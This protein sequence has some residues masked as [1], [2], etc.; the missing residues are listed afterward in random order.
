MNHGPCA[1][2]GRSGGPSG[3]GRCGAAAMASARS[4]LQ[5]EALDGSALV[6]R[7]TPG[8]NIHVA[9]GMVTL[10]HHRDPRKP[11]QQAEQ[12]SDQQSHPAHPHTS[13]AS[14]PAHATS[15]L[16]ARCTGS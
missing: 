1:G 3:V 5:R 10:A 4:L 16:C 13:P 11:S 15:T 12:A 7:A 2:G 9:G 14:D 8:I 6:R